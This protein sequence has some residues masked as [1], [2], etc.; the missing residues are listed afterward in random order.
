MKRSTPWLLAAS[1]LWPARSLALSQQEVD[2]LLAEIKIEELRAAD[3]VAVSDLALQAGPLRLR[4]TSGTVYPASPVAGRS[5]ELIFLGQGELE[6]DPDDPIEARQLEIY[7]GKR[8]LSEPISEAVLVLALDAATDA[9]VARPAAARVDNA[10]LEKAQALLVGWRAS[11]ER[12]RLNV[13]GAILADAVGDSGAEGYFAGAFEGENLGR[14]LY[15]VEPRSFEQVTL[16]SFEPLE[17]NDRERRQVRRHVRREQRRGR[18]LGVSADQLGQLDS[19]LSLPLQRD[20]RRAEGKPSFEPEHYDLEVTV[21]NNGEEVLGRARVRLRAT[22]GAGR[23]ASFG[24]LPDLQVTAARD[25]EGN[26]IPFFRSEGEALVFLAAAPP[27]GS[28]IELELE[29]Q[30]PAFEPLDSVRGRSFVMRDTLFWY[31]HAGAEDLATY[32]VKLRCPKKWQ[33]LGAGTLVAEGVDGSTRWQTRRVTRPTKGI[34]FQ[35]GDFETHARQLEG[36]RVLLAVDAVSQVVITGGEVL[37]WI[38]DAV[39]FLRGVF[40]RLPSEELTVVMTQQSFSQAM[41]GVITLSLDMMRDDAASA[42]QGSEDPRTIVAHEIAHQWWGIQVPWASYRDQWMSEALA[43]YSSALYGRERL[44][45]RSQWWPGP[46]SGWQA[47]LQASATTGDDVESL[48]PVVLGGRLISSLSP[49]AYDAIVYKK[50]ALVLNLLA[51]LVG[52]ESFHR[53][54]RWLAQDA[55]LRV[56]STEGFLDVIGRATQ[57]DLDPFARS[58]IYGTGVPEVEYSYRAEKSGEGDWRL[59]VEWAYTNRYRFRYRVVEAGRGLDV[60]REVVPRAPMAA[61]AEL[62]VPVEVPLRPAAGSASGK[63]KKARDED[64]AIGSASTTRTGY[65]LLDRSASTVELRLPE[66]PDKLVIDPGDTVLGRF[67]DVTRPTKATW[68]RRGQSAAGA[69]DVETAGSYFRRALET[70]A[71][72]P[73]VAGAQDGRGG[74]GENRPGDYWDTLAHL[75]LARLALDRRADSE[76]ASQMDS[77]R[78]SMKKLGPDHRESVGTVAELVQSRLDL[79][80]GDSS[81]VANRLDRLWKEGDLDDAEGLLLLAVAARASGEPELLTRVLEA[82]EERRADLGDIASLRAPPR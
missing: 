66:E 64:P 57:L 13:D 37:G 80:G 33:L 63:K 25:R 22:T 41:P 20:G 67:F 44:R 70:P 79:R 52:P 28:T 1:L 53:I 9:I 71:A 17:L 23:V 15:V 11:P 2:A 58:F 5:V 68:L 76:A 45:L 26:P 10:N 46:L 69:G 54:L 34:T 12:R 29:Y 40:G 73:G 3:A 51:N 82:A 74:E 43:N 47:D 35:F 32:E 65:L 19:W 78:A 31:P 38:T 56:L 18:L 16:G 75:A 55:G 39:E 60:V 21:E 81:R 8:R 36:V 24:L 59:R 77:A 6:L 14:F 7:T 42:L 4:L 50:G 62:V 48:G 27:A 30:G 72:S 61:D 49:E